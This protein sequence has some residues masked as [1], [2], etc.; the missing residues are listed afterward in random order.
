MH[1]I[2]QTFGE[3]TNTDGLFSGDNFDAI[4]GMAY[5]NFAEKGVKPM[6][7]M[8]MDQKLLKSNLFAFYLTSTKAQKY[9]LKSDITF[10]YYDDTKYKGEIHWNP[11]DFKLLYGVPFE[12]IKVNGKS[13]G[14]CKIPG[15]PQCLITFDSGTTHMIFPIHASNY[16]A[17]NKLAPTRGAARP[18]KSQKDFGDLT[19]VI[20]GKEYSLPPEDWVH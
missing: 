14:V 1:V 10:G 7:D 15:A 18:C 17:N 16:L 20:G 2:N 8:L 5:P 9:G 19:F 4:V 11:V 3:I 13:T 6:F 12:D